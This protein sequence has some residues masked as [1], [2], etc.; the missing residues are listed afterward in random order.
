MST[1]TTTTTSTA[2]TQPTSEP[3]RMTG[4]LYALLAVVIVADV[5]D[6]M[7]ST[8]TNIAAP[9][10]ERD[11]GG[12]ESLIK[13]LG[14]GYA[15]AMG[16]LL[17]VGGR[18]GDRYGRRR[19]FLIGMSGF[20]AASLV[21]GVSQDPTMLIVARFV[22]GGFGALMIPQGFGF[23]TAVYPRELLPTAFSVFGPVLGA[24]AVAGPLLAGFLIDA[25]IFGLGWRSI[26]LINIV[27]GTAGLIAA[28]RVLPPDEPR[29]DEVIDGLGAGLLGLSMLGLIYGLIT[30][31]TDGWTAVPVA[32]AVA[33][34]A[35][36]LAFAARQ[37]QASSPLI[38][39]SLLANRGF[40]SGL[41]L[42]LFFFAVVNG[43]AYVASLFLQTGL[44]RTPSQASV[45]LAPMM[46]GIIAASFV[47]RPAIDTLG[48]KLV[49]AGLAL[50]TLGGASMW[51]VVGHYG[52][53]M[54]P[55]GLAP[56]LLVLGLGMGACFGSIF[57]IAIGDL[58]ES[59]AGSASGSL[60]AVQQ[61][62]GAI[63]SAIV[64]TIYFTQIAHGGIGHA[65]TI[66]VAAVTGIALACLAPAFLLPTH[67][68]PGE[69]H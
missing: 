39:P 19:V 16:V 48:R 47:A 7:D 43:L 46:I 60:S 51:I 44:H 35:F 23:L 59:E 62:S 49:F 29:A 54:S 50:T 45:G 10:I 31:S 40:T 61:L 33:G 30:G 63:G 27:L 68:N 3:P 2:S 55:W 25:D 32:S 18:L 53:A 64:T 58:D 38:K 41:L 66:S 56:S 8:I 69:G 34:L 6:L 26:F 22:Q 15:L 57:D 4:F 28:V 52:T 17:V 13:W 65:M 1:T 67:T 36:G 12:G 11:L 42:G 21:C 5:L 20:V 9:S 14:A 37:R 24:S